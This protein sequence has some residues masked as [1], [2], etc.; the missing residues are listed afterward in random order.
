MQVLTGSFAIRLKGLTGAGIYPAALWAAI[1][2]K[3]P[4]TRKWLE[5][6]SAHPSV[7]SIYNEEAII[8]GT[9]ARLAKLRAAA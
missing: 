1:E 9:R 2:E 5:A 8:E 7:R 3:A 6:V 4:N